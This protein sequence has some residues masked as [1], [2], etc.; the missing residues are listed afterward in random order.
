MIEIPT[1]E[2][3]DLDNYENQENQP[4]C[5]EFND[6]MGTLESLTRCEERDCQGYKSIWQRCISKNLM[7]TENLG[8]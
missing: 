7:V 8:V 5:S 3:N 1:Y 2:L 6:C 4:E